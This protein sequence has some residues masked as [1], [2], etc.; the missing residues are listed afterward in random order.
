ML[1]HGSHASCQRFPS[2]VYLHLPAGLPCQ[3]YSATPCVRLGGHPNLVSQVNQALTKPT[4]LPTY[5]TS[6]IAVW[7]GTQCQAHLPSTR[8]WWH[9]NG[10][11]QIPFLSTVEYVRLGTYIRIQYSTCFQTWPSEPEVPCCPK[12]ELEL[13][14]RCITWRNT[15]WP[16]TFRPLIQVPNS[17]LEQNFVWYVCSKWIE[18]RKTPDIQVSYRHP[19]LLHPKIRKKQP[20]WVVLVTSGGWEVFGSIGGGWKG[21]HKPFCLRI[22][23]IFPWGG[24]WY[25]QGK[26]HFL[27]DFGYW[28][29]H[30]TT[31]IFTADLADL[32][33]QA[34]CGTSG[35][36]SWDRFEPL[37]A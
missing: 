17:I 13:E 26:K 3:C 10:W 29:N 27:N 36:W 34:F 15:G 12:L 5:P 16:S 22:F 18:T 21:H 9:Q 11:S 24:I 37:R 19:N 14:R 8:P 23:H 33:D 31:G 6:C 1:S 32:V 35:E 7:V 30:G 20:L 4:D 28:F 2:P 25:S